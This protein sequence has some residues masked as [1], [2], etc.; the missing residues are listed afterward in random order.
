MNFIFPDDIFVGIDDVFFQPKFN[1]MVKDYPNNK[2]VLFIQ[3]IQKI[4]FKYNDL[5]LNNHP[6]H[7]VFS[8]NLNS[9]EVLQKKLNYKQLYYIPDFIINWNNFFNYKINLVKNNNTLILI[10]N[11]TNE[12]T[13]NKIK[14]MVSKHISNINY[15]IINITKLL[16]E[17]YENS[18]I[19][20]I[21]EYK[22]II[23]DNIYIMEL[24][25]IYSTSCVII[26]KN[27]TQEVNDIFK[28]LDYIKYIHDIKD[29]EKNLIE[30][31]N[32]TSL[33]FNYTKIYNQNYDK[34]ISQFR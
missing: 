13:E 34:I 24:S 11:S 12:I 7:S 1:S 20:M 10:E 9:Y 23:T 26:R 25:A 15:N 33:N 27:Q 29:L 17:K 32:I 3:N 6:D 8:I 31:I 21:K 4:S 30:L 5:A 22:Y 19:D 28:N 2:I 16:E 18:I 14:K